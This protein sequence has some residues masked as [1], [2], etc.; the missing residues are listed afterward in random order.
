MDLSHILNH[1]GEDR[2]NYKFAVSPPIFQTSNFTFRDI[3]H[4][5]RSLEDE[6]NNPFYSR[7][8]NP[9]VAI[10]RKKI[11]ALEKAE[12]ALVLASGSAAVST[13]VIS[14]VKSGDHI[15]C[16]DKPYSWT[17]KLLVNLLNRFNVAYT[18]VDGT[19]MEAIK[20]AKQENTSLLYL[21]SPNSLTFELQDLKA[22]AKFAKANDLV[23]I[24]D[25]SYCS[26]YFQNPIE[27]GIDIVV[28]SATKFIAGHSDLVAGVICGSKEKIREIF[29]GEYMTLG[30]II[31]AHDAALMIRSL[32]TLPLRMERIAHSTELVVKAIS[33]HNKIAKL[34]YPFQ[35]NN[36]Q[37]DLA[38]SQMTGAPG[39]F[40]LE[41][42]ASS[43]S[44]V[45]AFCHRLK[46]FL[47][48]CSWGGHESLIF[49]MCVLH[50]S[51]NYGS[52]TLPW[53]FIR[54]YVGLEEAQI[55]IDDLV[56]SLDQLS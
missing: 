24:I 37:Y 42:E 29:Q 10:L 13:A 55:L 1:L 23:T 31:S 9:T 38:R 2:E 3:E 19:S 18:F 48:A 7:G 41:I 46:T 16:V 8:C 20:A 43:I 35:P 51:Q 47:P 32:R 52:G 5:R 50:N 12:D 44:Q 53:N 22:C 4:M 54:F 45:E 27:F 36:D 28:H 26:P 49:P 39:L 14:Q 6:L 56:S 11:A 21:E 17:N 40:S 30:G 33:H 15:I 34:H 25:N